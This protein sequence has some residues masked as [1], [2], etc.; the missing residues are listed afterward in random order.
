[1]K[2]YIV[3]YYDYNERDSWQI[4]GVFDSLAGACE[5]IEEQNKERGLSDE[6]T[7]QENEVTESPLDRMS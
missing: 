7:V 5:Y 2:V 3:V 4:E 6:L 1:M